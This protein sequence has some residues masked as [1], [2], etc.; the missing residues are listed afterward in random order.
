MAS[1]AKLS[2]QK[3]LLHGAVY[4][5]SRVLNQGAAFL[6]LPLYAHLLGSFGVGVIEVMSVARAF[7]GILLCQGLD[8][9]WFRLRFQLDG[10]DE[11]RAFEST[12]F[13]YL[14][15]SCTAGVLALWAFGD[16]LGP[17]LTPGV[18][19]VPLGVLSA[20]T[21]VGL[22][23]TSLVERNLQAEQRPFAFAVF[24]LVRTLV[25]TAAVVVFVAALRRGADGKIEAE[26]LAAILAALF[27]VYM[28]RPALVWSRARLREALAYGLPLVPHNLAWFAN[29]LLDRFLLNGLLG[30]QAVGVY[31][32]GYR[33]ASI[34]MMVGMAVNQA[35]APVFIEGVK[36]LERAEAARDSA[37]AEAVRKRVASM[38]FL[39]VIVA[40]ILA[41]SV[42]AAGREVLLVATTREFSNSWRVLAPV[43]GGVVAWGWYATLAQSIA[44]RPDTV[45]RLPI[46]TIAA[47]GANAVANL[48][49]I[50][51]FGIDGAAWA[52]L[53][54]NTLMAVLTVV[55]GTRILPLPYD[56]RRWIAV[57]AWTAASLGVLWGLDASLD[58]VLVR[59]AVK[60]A[61]LAFAVA[62]TLFLSGTRVRTLLDLWKRRSRQAMSEGPS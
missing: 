25:T 31:S 29:N 28:L 8:T 18:P 39:T 5:A 20:V 43:G 58:D 19:F 54:S 37:T 59:A 45:R 16:R 62:V 38:G 1:E 46:I 42:T 48:V 53:L 26:A 13:W 52:T 47:A 32:M 44:Y 33:L 11:R 6:L 17:V 3:L 22:I 40:C 24:G 15:A 49:L 60:T 61:W 12:V 50:P 23:F 56:F 27:S 41:Q 30:L 7:L 2:S 21:A 35:F 51:R 57:S 55:L 4:T 36:S 10:D 34:G 9:A 14:L